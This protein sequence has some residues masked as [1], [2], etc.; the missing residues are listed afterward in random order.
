MGLPAPSTAGTALVTGAS[1]GIGAEIARELAKRGHAVILVA[2]REERLRSLAEELRTD[3]GVEA[4]AIACDLSV[5]AERDRLERE[6]KAVG[7]S[8]EVLV[9]NA[10]YGMRGEFATRPRARMVGIVRVNVEAVVDLSSR[11]LPKMVERRR[12]AI[13][14]V[15]S[16]ASFQPLPGAATYGASKAFV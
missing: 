6:L 14:N 5:P 15:A 4:A 16:T 3:H 1:S 9:N 8:V 12:G 11:Y 13:I 2:R 7:R 10:G